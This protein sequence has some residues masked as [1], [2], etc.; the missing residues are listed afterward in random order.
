MLDPP[1]PD[2]RHFCPSLAAQLAGI[3]IF[4]DKKDGWM[5]WNG[6]KEKNSAGGAQAEFVMF[7]ASPV[8]STIVFAPTD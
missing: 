7:L 8:L 6:G 2:D 1:E 4:F 3:G 5:S